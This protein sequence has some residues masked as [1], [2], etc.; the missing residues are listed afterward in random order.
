MAYGNG[1]KKA[2]KKKRATQDPRSGAPRLKPKPKKK[3]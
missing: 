2:V 3:K 1:K